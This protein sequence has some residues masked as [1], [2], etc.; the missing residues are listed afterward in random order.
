[1]IHDLRKPRMGL[2]LLGAQ[3]FCTLGEGTAR[4]TY[5]ERKQQE[6]EWML[7]DAQKIADVTFT[8][9]VF[10]AED[11]I[12]AMDAFIRDKVD[13][14]LAIYLSWAED[15]AWVRFLRDMPPVP[16]LFAH[17]MRERIDLMD[18]HDDD[19]FTEY[20]CCGGLVG[21]QE[22]SGN[23]ANFHRP[24]LETALGTWEQILHRAQVFGNASRARA[25]LKQSRIGL[26]ACYNEA[27]WSTYV[28]PYDLFTKVGPE[29]TF[30]SISELEDGVN[31]VSPQEAQ[32]VTAD[33]AA[34]YPV[35]ADVDRDKFVA[36]V[37]ATLAME[38]L[39]VAH[40]LDLL[41]L[42][43]IDTMLF[44]KIGLRPGFYPTPDCDDLV[45]VPEGDLG[46]GL[47][48]YV[49]RL[50]TSGHVNFIE[51]FHID[52][53][54]NNFAAGH[55]GPN[56]YTDSGETQIARDV[57]FAASP[58]KYAGAPFAW[59]VFPEGTKTMLHCSEH[60][61]RFMFAV[62]KLDCLPCKPFLATYSHG[63]FRPVG[64][65]APEMFEKLLRL[66]VT[67]HY[68]LCAGDQAA[69]LRDL[70]RLLDFDFY[71]LSEPL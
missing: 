68:G 18:T 47:A 55:A 8:S 37:R 20:L 27:M 58:W 57:R 29:L 42:N 25:L 24:M 45:V 32:R 26:L 44:K 36:S 2:L 41:V 63:L 48:T 16:I 4:G 53:P 13:Y 40:Q 31:A 52:L 12:T 14:V 46:G 50:L 23:N 67:Q 43:D 60:N 15:F 19:E 69:A 3:R 21:M 35:K 6:A 9:I 51:P 30:L 17:R 71:D 10:S 22:A 59:H 28:H 7:S 5:L 38:R 65:S 56:D 33:I 34:R 54:N 66:G 61:G 62:T 64:Q 1:M 70:A 11:V 39:A 49:L